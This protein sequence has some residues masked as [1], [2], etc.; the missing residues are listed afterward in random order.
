MVITRGGE[1]VY[2]QDNETSR[3]FPPL[4]CQAVDTTGAGD[5]FA[6]GL[7]HRYLRDPSNVEAFVQFGQATA[8]YV[9]ER[10]GGVIPERMPTEPE[11][12]K[13]LK[14]IGG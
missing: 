4:M 13:K 12:E 6:A 1:G 3:S 9:I 8:C 10:S 14:A 5:A 11:V 7:I 2:Y